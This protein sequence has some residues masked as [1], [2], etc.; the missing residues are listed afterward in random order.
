MARYFIKTFGC[1]VNQAESDDLH[2][3]LTKMGMQSVPAAVEAD[4]II[5]NTCT[6]TGEADRK[7]RKELRR[8]ARLPNTTAVIVTG[9]SA[10][11]G[12][13][14]LEGLDEKVIVLPD[15]ESIPEYLSSYAESLPILADLGEIAELFAGREGEQCSAQSSYPINR[16][17]NSPSIAQRVEQ[18]PPS[19]LVVSKRIRV[20]VKVQDGCEDFCSYCIVPFARGKCSSVSVDEVIAKIQ[21]LANA[22][23]K[24]VIL[25]GI[26]LGNYSV[27]GADDILQLLARIQAET[28][29]YRVR[30]SSIEPRHVTDELL[31]FFKSSKDDSPN[32][33]CEHLH[34]PLQSGSDYVLGDMNRSYS[35]DEFRKLVQKIRAANPHVAITT[36]VIVGYPSEGDDDFA[37]TLELVKELRFAKVHVFRY[38]PREGTAAANLRPLNSNLVRKRAQILQEQADKDAHAFLESKRGEELELI[39]ERVDEVEN[40]ATGMSREY[41]RLTIPASGHKPGDLVKIAPPCT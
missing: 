28:G 40:T 7:V 19:P 6:V 16:L 3:A 39:I 26:N 9:C 29:I 17:A 21:S 35:V 27:E 5:V 15:R 14:E 34:I 37:Q 20:P 2:A 4:F 13:D 22:G 32:I 18:C 24:E 30:L 31:D 8:S 23:T 11:L 25:T 33:L 41:L 36:D 10:V 38:S 12:R 1:K